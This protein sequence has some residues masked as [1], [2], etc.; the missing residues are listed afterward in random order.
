M[1]L[2]ANDFVLTPNGT[3]HEHGVSEDG[4]PCIWQDGLDIPLVNAMEAGFYKVHLTYIKHKHDLSIT[5]LVCGEEPHYVLTISAGINLIHHYLNTNGANL[6]GVVPCSEAADGSV[7]DD[8]L[9]H[10]TNPLTGGPVMPTI[11]QYAITV[12][13]LLVKLIAIREVLFIK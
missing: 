4:L 11:E 7:F 12:R 5:P 6:R 1:M 10:Y 2:E 8:V 3:W 9:M 13:A